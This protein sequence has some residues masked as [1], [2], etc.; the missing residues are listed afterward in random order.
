MKLEGRFC[1]VI[2]KS[3]EITFILG[4]FCI[5]YILWLIKFSR[6]NVSAPAVVKQNLFRG[7]IH[8]HN[9]FTLV[10]GTDVQS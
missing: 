9:Q 8:L 4:I 1:W 2:S 7:F 10:E 5:F 3:F 6:N